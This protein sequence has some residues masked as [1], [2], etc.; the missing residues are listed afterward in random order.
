MVVTNTL[1]TSAE[2]AGKRDIDVSHYARSPVQ[3]AFTIFLRSQCMMELPEDSRHP[4]Y[5]KRP[6]DA[7]HPQELLAKIGSKMM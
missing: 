6:A 3:Q 5:E 4:K 1:H 7:H 2:S